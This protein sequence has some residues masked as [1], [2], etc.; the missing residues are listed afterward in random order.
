MSAPPILLHADPRLRACVDTT[1][2]P[3][4]ASPS[5]GVERRMIERDGGEAARA[6]SLVR[7]APD[8]RFAAHRHP[9]GEEILVLEGTFGDEFG[10]Y[11]AG[12][13]LRNPPG[14]AHAP[15]TNAGCVIFVKLRHMDPREQA[16]VVVEPADRGWHASDHAGLEVRPLGGFIG[17]RAALARMAA[18]TVLPSRRF[19]GGLELFVLR[20]ELEETGAGRHP[21]GTWLRLPPGGRA[22]L[23][24]ASDCTVFAKT[25]HLRRPW[26]QS[27]R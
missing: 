26:V 3:W 15:R 12:T 1:A 11:P 5:P 22:G 8:S 24:A 19:A 7:Y 27:G 4:V 6:T 9:L 16:R 18:G 10:D 20:G 14:S 23:R 2:L 13:Y 21:P 17:E 25:G